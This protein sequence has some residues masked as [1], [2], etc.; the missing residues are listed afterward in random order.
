MIH[1]DINEDKSIQ[2]QGDYMTVAYELSKL[3]ASYMVVYGFVESGSTEDMYSVICAMSDKLIPESVDQINNNS[4]MTTMPR[5]VLN[6]LLRTIE[7]E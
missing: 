3:L 1:I 4:V 5:G 6:K 7:D 2:L